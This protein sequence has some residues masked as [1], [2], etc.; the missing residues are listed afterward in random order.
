MPN[1]RECVK[2][3]TNMDNMTANDIKKLSMPNTFLQ[4][5]LL[6]VSG[7]SIKVFMWFEIGLS[8]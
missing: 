2:K 5:K 8:L 4:R 6:S 7:H 1:A 3:L